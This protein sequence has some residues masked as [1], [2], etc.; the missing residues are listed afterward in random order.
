VRA[1]LGLLRRNPDFRKAFVAE[2][3][4]FGGDWF[5]VVPLLT[6]LPELTGTGLWGGLVLA[7][8]TAVIA[9]LLPYAG[10]LADRLD[11]RRIAIVGSVVSAVAVTLLFFVRSEAT[12]WVALVAI[13]TVAAAKA[14][15][16]PAMQAAVPNLVDRE[17]L[18][19]ANVLS[20]SAWGTMLVVGASAGG[21]LA[22]VV[23]T[24]VCFAINA[25]CMVAAAVLLAR[26][27]RPFQVSREDVEPVPAWRAI[28]EASAYVCREPTV[29]ALVTVKSAVGLGNGVLTLFPLLASGFFGVGAIGTGL[30]YAARGVGALVGPLVL[31]G[32][33]FRRGRLLPGLALSMALYGV[34]YIAFGFT[35]WFAIAVVLVILAHLGGGANWVLSNYA[36]QAHVP[37]ALRGRVLSFDFM[38][39]TLAIALS[40]VVAG[41][42]SDHVDARL[43]VSLFGA[44][45]LCYAV[46]WALLTSKV[47]L[48]LG[49]AGE[50]AGVTVEP[51][52][53]GDRLER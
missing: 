46:V 36:L 4:L 44:V 9:L 15:I 31:R 37:D 45:T 23:G 3:V 32:W 34:S 13:G 40:Q 38:L 20:G 39:A 10:A 41:V 47:R 11:R 28:R 52:P 7:V 5:A 50:P 8:D 49:S 19:A 53:V 26:V 1:Y 12:A 42:L 27:R 51:P 21:V 16:T 33:L 30:L 43:L 35:P 25:V 24:D 17:D 22:E 48:A 6:L 14:F 29:G 18:P 2:L